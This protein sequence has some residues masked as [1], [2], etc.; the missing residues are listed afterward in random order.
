[1]NNLNLFFGLFILQT[2]ITL[3]RNDTSSECPHSTAVQ[4]GCTKGISQ[5]L[6]TVPDVARIYKDDKLY[7]CDIV[8]LAHV[9]NPE[10][11]FFEH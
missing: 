7:I 3:Q 9:R 6:T 11:I 2:Y 4:C 8:S 1:M 10:R 5:W